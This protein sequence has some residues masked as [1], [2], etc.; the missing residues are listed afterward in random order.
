M[1]RGDPPLPR[2]RRLPLRR[3]NR[4]RAGGRALRT[5]PTRGIAAAAAPRLARARAVSTVNRRG[6]YGSPSPRLHPGGSRPAARLRHQ[7]GPDAT[8]WGTSM[9]PAQP[10]VRRLAWGFGPVPGPGAYPHRRGPRRIAVDCTCL[11]S[12]EPVSPAAG[13]VL[14]LVTGSLARK[15]HRCKSIGRRVAIPF[16]RFPSVGR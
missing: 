11:V 16:M 3:L 13:C 7:A 9:S 15:R 10:G 4:P 2:R 1:A 6:R 12:Q 14:A 5:V 8:R